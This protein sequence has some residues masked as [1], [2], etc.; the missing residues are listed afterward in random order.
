[1]SARKAS[2]FDDLNARFINIFALLLPKTLCLLFN[3]SLNEGIFPDLWKIS[4]I[5]PIFKSGDKNVMN[6]YRSIAVLPIFSKIFEK[7][8]YKY[9][10][11]YLTVNNILSNR[12]FGFR[13]SHST[14]DA[15]LGIQK[16]ILANADKKMKVCVITLDLAKAFDTINHQFLLLKLLMIGLD[17]LSIALFRSYLTDGHN[18]K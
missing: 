12:Q 4:K 14:V 10:F 11:N 2:G 9:L 7:I 13:K 1:V 17:A 5:I 6:N 8:V 15:L 3:K 18:F 16:K